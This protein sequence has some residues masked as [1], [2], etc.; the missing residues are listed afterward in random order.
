MSSWSKS[1][2]CAVLSIFDVLLGKVLSGTTKSDHANAFFNLMYTTNRT[3]SKEI[4]KQCLLG[5]T[6]LERKESKLENLKKKQI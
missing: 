3:S 6:S 2:F 1:S 4:R 5:E